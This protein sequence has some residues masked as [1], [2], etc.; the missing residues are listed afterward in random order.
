[1]T[2]IPES[3]VTLERAGITRNDA[4]TLRRIAMTLHR[5]FELECGD[6]ND[7]ASWCI[8]RGTYKKDGFEHNDNGRPYLE[9]HVHADPLNKPHYTP[10]ADRET[11]ARNRLT[12]LIAKYPQYVAFVQTDPRGASLYIVSKDATPYDQNYTR[13]IGVYK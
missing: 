10:L 1:M 11:G 9:R 2:S 8:V 13:G 5:W 3:V 4:Y 12:K 7:Y 6:S